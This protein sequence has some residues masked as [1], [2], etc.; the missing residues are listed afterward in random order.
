MEEFWKLR[1]N[2][3]SELVADQFGIDLDRD[4]FDIN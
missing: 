4:V 1:N 2:Q 3:T